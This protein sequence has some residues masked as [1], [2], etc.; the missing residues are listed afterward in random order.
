MAHTKKRGPEDI[1][2]FA[3]LTEYMNEL[4]LANVPDD[5]VQ[6]ML[7]AWTKGYAARCKH[8]A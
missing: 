8:G 3:A 7:V 4:V 6:L 2:F 5:T 1:R